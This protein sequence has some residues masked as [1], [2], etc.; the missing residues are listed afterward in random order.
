MFPICYPERKTNLTKYMMWELQFL[1]NMKCQDQKVD[2]LV[3]AVP[4]VCPEKYDFTVSFQESTLTQFDIA[5]MFSS[6][7][8]SAASPC[9]RTSSSPEQETARAHTILGIFEN[10]QKKSC[11]VYIPCELHQEPE[12]PVTFQPMAKSSGTIR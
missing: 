10:I 2:C 5:H 6:S 9:R 8:A 11:K 4:S 7:I 3:L 1:T 12:H